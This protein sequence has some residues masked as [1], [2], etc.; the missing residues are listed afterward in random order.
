MTRLNTVLQV[1]TVAPSLQPLGAE[2]LSSGWLKTR[3]ADD[4]S[5]V[6]LRLQADIPG[7]AFVRATLLGSELP[8]FSGQGRKQLNSAGLP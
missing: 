1:E 5:S 8:C 6:T 2:M 4:G 3:A 7:Q